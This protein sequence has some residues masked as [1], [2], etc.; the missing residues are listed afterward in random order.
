MTNDRLEE[1]RF[2]H[3]KS[4]KGKWWS[5]KDRVEIHSYPGEQVFVSVPECQT[6]GVTDFT[7][8][9]GGEYNGWD[10]I[11]ASKSHDEYLPELLKEVDRLG[12]IIGKTADGVLLCDAEKLYCPK[13]ASECRQG[14]GWVSCDECPNPDDGNYPHEGPLPLFDS[15]CFAIQENARNAIAKVKGGTHE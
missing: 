5:E 15:S 2:M 1:I 13:C 3:A 6:M 12:E 4:T 9:V 10:W 7:M 11:F 14:P 8:N